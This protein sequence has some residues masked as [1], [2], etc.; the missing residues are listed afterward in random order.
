M[1][2]E[3]I[4]LLVLLSFAILLPKQT[5]ALGIGGSFGADLPL[6]HTSGSKNEV[7]I[8]AEGFYRVDPWEV[9]FHYG[10]QGVDTYSVVLGVKHFFTQSV[11]RPYVEGALGPVIVNSP[12]KS[13]LAYGVKP[14]VTLGVDIGMNAWLSTSVQ[15]R[16]F[17]LA[18]F[19]STDSGK[20]EA[21]HG[22]T[23][24]GS[25]IFWFDI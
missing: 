21:N 8:S 16:Y 7:G 2:L 12:R 9:R 23:L 22:F 6:A 5:E 13:N 15:A 14:E 10:D 19:G 20:F 3:F 11:I 25:L 18:Y 4:G 24:N 1:R 17:G